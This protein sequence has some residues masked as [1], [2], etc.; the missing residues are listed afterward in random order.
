MGQWGSDIAAFPGSNIFYHQSYAQLKASHP[1]KQ[2]IYP[3]VCDVYPQKI[4]Q[5]YTDLSP[6]YNAMQLFTGCL[7]SATI[8][9]LAWRAGFLNLSGAFAAAVVGGLVFGLG[10]FPW[11][12]LLL[13]FFVSSSALSRVFRKRKASLIEKYSKGSRRDWE[14]VLAN[15]GFG[16]LLVVA[17]ALMGEP[18][19]A[20]VAF[21]GA[22]AAVNADT[23]ATELGVLSTKPP[24]L[25]TTGQVVDKGTSG[26]ISG[27]GNLAVLGGAGLIGI[28]AG[29]VSPENSF[30]A[31]VVII[32]LGGAAGALFDSLLGA[33]LQAIFFCH[34][35]QK[36]TERHPRHTCQSQTEHLHGWYWMNNEMVNFA[37]SVV[38]AGVAAGLWLVLF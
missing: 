2:A 38:G 24:R 27:A 13:V 17:N 9:A 8:S 18:L 35:C 4:E 15:G 16:T 28:A 25:I 12:V 5:L 26:A 29:L 20:F 21:A 1:N 31:L 11:A 36:Q 7:L 37:C 10:G 23:W 14:Q 6:E 3:Q 22:M 19:W 33:S 30:S 32:L 34:T